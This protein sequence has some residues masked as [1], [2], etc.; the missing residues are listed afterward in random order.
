MLDMILLRRI[1]VAHREQRNRHFPLDPNP[2]LFVVHRKQR[3]NEYSAQL[4][5]L[6]STA[7]ALQWPHTFGS[8]WISNQ[9]SHRWHL[10]RKEKIGVE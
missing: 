9:P 10:H 1:S 7:R 4:M 5:G 2:H 8:V 3:H 6:A